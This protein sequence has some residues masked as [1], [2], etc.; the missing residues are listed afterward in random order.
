MEERGRTSDTAD[1]EEDPEDGTVRK[2]DCGFGLGTFSN[3]GCVMEE[4]RERLLVDRDRFPKDEGIG[5]LWIASSPDR[6][7]GNGT[8][9]FGRGIVASR[10]F[11]VASTLFRG[12]RLSFNRRSSG[13][14][15]CDAPLVP[16]LLVLVYVIGNDG[17]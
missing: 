4:G 3:C 17:P 10:L 15:A 6:E 1:P 7:L 8:I 13:E 14:S 5:I 12:A 11:R 2:L 16:V 9:A